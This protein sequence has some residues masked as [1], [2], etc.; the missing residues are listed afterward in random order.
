[1]IVADTNVISEFMRD[2]P[3]SRVWAWAEGVATGDLAMSAV[4]IE[5]IEY[6]IGLV[7]QGRR[8]RELEAA[9]RTVERGFREAVIP[10]D[11]DAA[12]ATASLLV[13]VRSSGRRMSRADAQIAG[14]CVAS[15][16][17]LATRNIK[18]FAAVAGLEM[19]NPFT[20]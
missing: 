6:G 20:V 15:G 5:E 16:Y 11:G 8:R 13:E 3:D 17:A 12:R 14:T 1:M 4:S 2:L 18:D 9:W 7:P 19:V 10:Y